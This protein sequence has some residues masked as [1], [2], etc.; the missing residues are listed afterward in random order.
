M[1]DDSFEKPPHPRVSPYLRRP[2]RTLEEAKE[3]NGASSHQDRSPA[4]S[5]HRDAASTRKQP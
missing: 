4:G 5:D 3:D 1:A 2:L